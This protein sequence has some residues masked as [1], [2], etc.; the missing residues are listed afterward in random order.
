LGKPVW[1]LLPFEVDWRWMIGRADS[2]WYPTMRL[3]RQ[4]KC[5]DWPSAISQIEVALRDPSNLAPVE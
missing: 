5:G 1:T 3:F 4:P 2:P